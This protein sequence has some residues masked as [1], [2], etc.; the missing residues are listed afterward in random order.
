MVAMGKYAE[1]CVTLRLPTSID[2][3]L[4]DSFFVVE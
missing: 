4:F 2:S 3:E 1:V